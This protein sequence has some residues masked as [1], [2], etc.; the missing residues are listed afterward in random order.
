MKID[1]IKVGPSCSTFKYI[2][3]KQSAKE[4]AKTKQELKD[5]FGIDWV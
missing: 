3:V 4:K 5:M 2:P 1:Y